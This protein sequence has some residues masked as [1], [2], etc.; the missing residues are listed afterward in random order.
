VQLFGPARGPV[1]QYKTDPTL[2]SVGVAA[3]YG[4][5]IDCD[6][7]FMV[8]IETERQTVLLFDGRADPPVEIGR[9]GGYG[10]RAGQFQGLAD[11]VLDAATR[12][13]WTVDAAQD[14]L[15][16]WRFEFDSEAEPVFDPARI[17]LIRSRGELGLTRGLGASGSIGGG[18]SVDLTRAEDGR[19]HLL[20]AAAGEMIEVSA[21]LRSAERVGAAASGDLPTA[22]A[23]SYR[24]CAL[25][26][27]AGG[28]TYAVDRGLDRVVVFEA[29]SADPA[30]ISRS[31]GGR[32]IGPGE[33]WKPSGIAIDGRGRVLVVDHG[34]HR[35]Q[36]FEQDGTFVTAF[37]SR[38][39]VLPAL[40]PAMERQR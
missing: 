23:L 40:E 39:Y 18:A 15:T 1:A 24:V 22:L 30:T 26:R 29:G 33:F 32:G 34:N 13:L 2:G 6:G 16:E 12:R 38:L 35:V 31:W 21:D 4:P 37:G 17:K 20:D 8:L 19:L 3:H 5:V 9:C 10:E 7:P 28:S 25:D 14:R 27:S 36:V 11:V